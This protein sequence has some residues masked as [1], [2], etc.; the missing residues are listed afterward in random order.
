MCF[1]RN[2]HDP[3]RLGLL[4]VCV[5]ILLQLSGERPFGV[6]MNRP[7]NAAGPAPPAELGLVVG[8]STGADLVA[9][10]VYKMLCDSDPVTQVSLAD[11][12]LTIICNLSPYTKSFGMIWPPSK[13]HMSIVILR[14]AR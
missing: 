8:V 11:V 2:R 12:C 1:M 3:S 6:N 7:I 9:C 5:F 14:Y 13:L 10:T 4:H